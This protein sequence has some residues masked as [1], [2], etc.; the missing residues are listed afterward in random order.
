VNAPPLTKAG[1]S[2]AR[3]VPTKSYT[4]MRVKAHEMVARGSILQVTGPPGVGKTETAQRVMG[5]LASSYGVQG[6]WIQLGDR[7][8]S[9]EVV[10]QL[11]HAVGI[12][13]R[14]GESR[15]MLALELNDR[16]TEA[17]RCVWIDEAH[18][19]GASALT[20]LRTLHDKGGGRWMLGLV[21][22][23]DLH[24]RLM[25]DQPELASR[26]GRR[27]EMRRINDRGTLLAT[28][29]LWHPLLTGCEDHRLLRMNRVGP[30]GNFRAWSNLLATLVSLSEV[31]GGLSE[32]VEAAALWQC[33][34]TLP[35]E[36]ARWL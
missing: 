24:K 11:L 1:I 16:L 31:D 25:R 18:Y 15:W 35:A 21:G 27:V 23:H 22:S 19:L 8:T 4:E 30:K 5:D 10:T 32:R 7:P 9:K 12:R 3:F 14:R 29:N 6:L 17:A 20:T 26:V 36:L 34:Y 28:L 33:N 2:D 13:A